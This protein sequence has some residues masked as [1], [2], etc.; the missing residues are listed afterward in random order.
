[1]DK[2]YLEYK[3]QSYSQKEPK[4]IVPINISEPGLLTEQKESWNH[5]VAI[6]GASEGLRELAEMIVK[7]SRSAIDAAVAVLNLLATLNLKKSTINRNVKV[8]IKNH[9]GR[10]F[11]SARKAVAYYRKETER[12]YAPAL[13]EKALK[14]REKDLGER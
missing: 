12:E 13:F 5:K 8:M 1:M 2:I 10:A 4:D 6:D 14:D 11:R 3:G 9:T 7:T